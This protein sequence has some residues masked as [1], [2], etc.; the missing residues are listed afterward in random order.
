MALPTLSFSFSKKVA[1]F[2]VRGKFLEIVILFLNFCLSMKIGSSGV[3][4][5]VFSE[6]LLALS[7]F[8]VWMVEGP[9]S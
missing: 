5:D 9:P 2:L 6:V 4:F 1:V 7:A 3:L 8:F